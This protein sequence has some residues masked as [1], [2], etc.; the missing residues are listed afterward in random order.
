MR[1]TEIAAAVQIK[2]GRWNMVS[3]AIQNLD[4]NR[5][6]IKSDSK[7]T[8]AFWQIFHT[9]K[10]AVFIDTH[11]SDGADYQYTMTLITS[12]RDKMNPVIADYVGKK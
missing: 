9:L 4:L 1:I 5:D 6:F 3:E 7:N 2:T 8:Y 11:T 10:P 12:Q